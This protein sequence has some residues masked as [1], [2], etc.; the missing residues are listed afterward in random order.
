MP[1]QPLLNDMTF[2]PN[3]IDEV[4]GEDLFFEVA[5]SIELGPFDCTQGQYHR[6]GC[7]T[8]REEAYW[9]LSRILEELRPYWMSSTVVRAAH[10]LTQHSALE[11]LFDAVDESSHYATISDRIRL[12]QRLVASTLSEVL[13]EVGTVASCP[14]VFLDYRA[15]CRYMRSDAAISEFLDLTFGFEGEMTDE[16]E[17][18]LALTWCCEGLRKFWSVPSVARSLQWL[19]HNQNV[20]GALSESEYC[21]GVD[22]PERVSFV[23]SLVATVVERTEY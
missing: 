4:L 10:C 5:Q 12:S 23:F 2:I 20:L 1:E 18:L 21:A 14:K 3:L 11:S 17:I 19:T 15:F 6:L 8:P 16:R 7:L 22:S 13:A 9:S